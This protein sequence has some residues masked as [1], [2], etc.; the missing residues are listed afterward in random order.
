LG[1]PQLPDGEFQPPMEMN[2]GEK[3]FKAGIERAF[4]DRR[5]TIGRVAILTQSLNGRLA[6]HYCGPCERGCS[7]GSYFSSQSSTLPAARATGRLTIVPNAIVH[8]LI[9]DAE[10]NRVTGVRVVDTTTHE[11]REYYGRLVFLCAS[12][13]NTTRVLLNSKS[14][15]FPDGLANSSG[16]LGHYL[17]DHHFQA[18][19]NGVIEGL[20]DRY[21]QGNRPNGIYIPRFRN[22]GDEASRRGDYVRGFGYQGGAS[23]PGWGRGSGERGFGVELKRQL[24]DPGG[25]RMGIT[26][27]G[28]C[29]PRPDN[30]VDLSDQTD[31]FGIP[32]L[33]IHCT[34]SDNE[35]AMRKDMAA[36]AAEML[37]AAGCKEVKTYDRY[38]GGDALGAEPGLAIHEMGTARMGRDPKTSVLNAYNQA[39]DVPNLFV[40][41][42]A[43][44]A[45]SACQNPSITYMALTARACDYAVT[46]M[47][48]GNL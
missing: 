30:H 28:E 27:F 31:E 38:E 17:M 22:L 23:R 29:L 46:E 43:C 34:W 26:G 2:A 21:Y 16:V 44:M 9:Y 35:I 12:T 10:R 40:T 13:L 19:A 37:E 36:S 42:G 4:P 1:L 15:R 32:L 41:D 24:R 39:H 20:L 8:S 11:T 6:C 47:K 7:T 48:R 5:V 33:R 3:F 45:S 14:A 25:W 18:G